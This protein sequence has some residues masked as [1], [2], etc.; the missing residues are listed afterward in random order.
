MRRLRA[1]SFSQTDAGYNVRGMS[2]SRQDSLN[3]ACFPSRLDFF[4]SPPY[5]PFCSPRTLAKSMP[6]RIFQTPS[7]DRDGDSSSPTVR[8]AAPEL[9]EDEA[10]WP[11]TPPRAFHR[12]RR[13]ALT[14]VTAP[15]P[16]LSFRRAAT[17][18]NP[19]ADLVQMLRP[20]IEH[21]SSSDDDGGDSGDGEGYPRPGQDRRRP[22]AR[23]FDPFVPGVRRRGERYR[24]HQNDAR[25]P[26]SS[27][28]DYG[29]PVTHN[30]PSQHVVVDQA[31]PQ[32][33]LT[34]TAGPPPTWPLNLADTRNPDPFTTTS[35]YAVQ[36]AA[37]EWMHNGRYAQAPRTVGSA[38]SPLS[39]YLF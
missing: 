16:N 9:P 13:N 1:R 35:N 33:S 37:P 39:R 2:A 25:G 19:R 34:A 5:P 17:H 6:G 29:W 14:T 32:P 20:S 3:F 12:R 18:G 7:P 38:L 4:S 30:L 11:S 8:P 10:G 15:V 31:M 36:P 28:D 27:P 22:P 26:P 23:R 21:D 24:V